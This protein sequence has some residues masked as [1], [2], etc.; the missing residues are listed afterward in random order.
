M[1]AR[2]SRAA[3]RAWVLEGRISRLTADL[4]LLLR[5]QHGPADDAR[6]G[7]C[8]VAMT[9]LSVATVGWSLLVPAAGRAIAERVQ[10]SLATMTSGPP[11]MDLKGGPSPGSSRSSTCSASYS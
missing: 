1:A 5:Q 4:H 8:A 6:L 9:W 3:R 10:M 11:S 7:R 2:A